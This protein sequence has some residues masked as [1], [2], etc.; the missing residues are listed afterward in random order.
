M[1]KNLFTSA[2]SEMGFPVRVYPK[3]HPRAHLDVFVDAKY[4]TIM[5]C[6]SKC[7]R[8]ISIIHPRDPEAKK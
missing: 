4:R 6:C 1:C 8:P 7:D 3:C 2:K 5:L